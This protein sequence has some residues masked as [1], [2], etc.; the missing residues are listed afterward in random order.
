M[1]GAVKH[2]ISSVVQSATGWVGSSLSQTLVQIL[3]LPTASGVTVNQHTAMNHSAAFACTRILSASGAVLPLNLKRPK[4]GGGSINA[5]EHR[6]YSILHRKPNPRMTSMYFRLYGLA[7]QINAGNFYSEIERNSFGEIVALHPIHSSRVEYEEQTDG[8]VIYKVHNNDGTYLGLING[9]DL[10][11]RCEMLHIPSI[12]PAADGIGG[13]GTIARARESIGMGLVVREHG[14]KTFANG[15]RPTVAIKLN[16]SKLDPEARNRFRKEWAESTTGNNRGKPVVLDQTMELEKF[17]WSNED[18]QFLGTLEYNDEDVARW[19]GVPPHMIQILKRAT[20]NNI[21]MQS[22]EFVVYSLVPWIEMWDQTM[23][24]A[25]LSPEE[26]Q[27]GYFVKH[28]VN[29]LLRGDSKSRGEFYKLL[30]NLGVITINEIRELEDLNPIGP[31]GDKHFVPLNMTTA[32]RAGTEQAEKQQA[33]M[34]APADKTNQQIDFE[35]RNEAAMSVLADALKRMWTKEANAAKR[36]AKNSK[37][38]LA[39]LEEFYTAH[40]ATFGEAIMPFNR[41]A[42]LIELPPVNHRELIAQSRQLLESQYDSQPA[43]S[44]A[45]AVADEVDTWTTSRITNTIEALKESSH[46]VA[47]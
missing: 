46:A 5:T 1:I 13:T 22:T 3:G 32:E 10:S 37:T 24:V 23:E 8:S 16:G 14:A 15:C 39:W 35:A 40:E 30:W 6:L 18:S 7:Q 20:F 27:A 38:F 34:P 31:D 41:I 28:N 43:E 19:Y 9:A 42:A 45:D 36:A 33:T 21:E 12:Y 2:F 4:E 47:N 44:F 17:S 29:A 11:Q 25:L 26:Q